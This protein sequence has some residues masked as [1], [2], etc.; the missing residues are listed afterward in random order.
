MPFP[1]PIRLN[2]IQSS[3]LLSALVA[4]LGLSLVSSAGT[5][6]T[7]WYVDQLA[8]GADDGTS[9]MD[10]YTDLQS[11]LTAAG[12]DDQIWVAKGVYKPTPTADRLVSF[13]LKDT[14]K[15][16]GG[17]PSGGGDGTFG[18][19]NPDA[20]TNGTILSGDVDS[21]DTNADGNSIA[22]ATTDLV[23]GNSHHVITA[24]S[25]SAGT[26][27][28]GFHVTAGQADTAAGGRSGAG[29]WLQSSPITVGNC[30]FSGNRAT[31][32][33]GGIHNN[34][35]NST[36]TDCTFTGNTANIG[37]GLSC[38]GASPTVSNCRFESNTGF[39]GAAM[40]NVFSSSP[41]VND[42]TFSK[43]AASVTA[44]AVY[45]PGSSSATFTGCFFTENSAPNAGAC[46]MFSANPT[47]T[48]CS[49][50]GN[51]AVNDGGAVTNLA[52]SSP[53]FTNCILTGNHAIN[54]GGMWNNSSSPIL[55]SC[56][57]AANS[58]S[59]VNGGS[60][61]LSKSA[62]PIITNC[63]FWNNNPSPSIVNDI[64]TPLISHSLVHNS[65]G[66]TSWDD[67]FGADGGNNIDVDPAFVRNPDP[68][69]SNWTTLAD[70]DY[71]DLRLL[72][73]SPAFDVGDNAVNAEPTDRAGNMRIQ[74]TTIDLGAFEG[75]L[76]DYERCLT[77]Y[78]T[79]DQ[80]LNAALEASVWGNSADPD[81]D[82]LSNAGEI[83]TG[84]SPIVGNDGVFTF[85]HFDVM[86]DSYTFRW[87]Q[88]ADTKSVT[89]TPM[90]SENLATYYASNTG[91]GGGPAYAISAPV[92]VADNGSWVEMES[93]MTGITG[94]RAF[95]G[96]FYQAP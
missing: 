64:A 61:L 63:I 15:M 14:V 82:G 47:F 53:E 56:T 36:I 88:A 90:W 42:C 92:Q 40:G 38:S 20:T 21:N 93:V 19:R 18:A 27:L 39:S 58:A 32:F 52:G 71:G 4:L 41:V 17:F 68:G 49:F 28:D 77:N 11:A 60:A 46:Y 31:S 57:F 13:V 95:I 50:T 29:L 75:T 22:E 79:M 94:V 55:T 45:T 10:A 43:N 83:Y 85:E 37:G 8:I 1:Q 9:W 78:F 87:R 62:V 23:G 51:S 6:T 54:G 35:S 12:P 74:N 59:G 7:V 69:D 26:I 2:Q 72:A 81:A 91:P 70:N 30:A 24:Q 3:P 96:L 5:P 89:V 76:N 67:D 16:Y 44:G 25:I 34:A 73:G 48:N 33:G 84:F 86:V 80:L 66:S 65:G